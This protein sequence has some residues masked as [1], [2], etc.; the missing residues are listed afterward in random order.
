MR[1]LGFQNQADL[2]RLYAAA[3]VLVLPSGWGETWGL[4]VNEA[5]AVGTPCVVS[6]AVGCAPDLV[7]PGIDGEIYPATD[8][9]G[10]G[11]GAS[12]ES[13]ASPAGTTRLLSPRVTGARAALRAGDRPPAESPVR[14]RRGLPRRPPYR[15]P[16]KSRI[17][18]LCDGMVILGGMERRTI[19]D[20]GLRRRRWRRSPL[21]PRGIIPRRRYRL[22]HRAEQ[23][24]HSW[25]LDE[26]HD[27]PVLGRKVVPVGPSRRGRRAGFQRR[28]ASGPLCADRPHVVFL[29]SFVKRPEELASAPQPS[30]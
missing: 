5:M 14:P 6:D 27:G 20:H 19:G 21:R 4:V 11:R 8:I 3:D 9:D 12:R 17:L 10:S 23:S 1:W 13:V 25:S 30:D 16:A 29:A 18:A 2:P 24:G 28:G 7:E 15:P 26:S 22:A